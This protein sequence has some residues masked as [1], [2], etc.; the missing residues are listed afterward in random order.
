MGSADATATGTAI[1]AAKALKAMEK[2]RMA[3]RVLLNMMAD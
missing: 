2:A 1:G 3:K